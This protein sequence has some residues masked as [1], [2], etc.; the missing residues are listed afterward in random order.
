MG[1]WHVTCDFL[2]RR[3]ESGNLLYLPGGESPYMEYRENLST[4]IAVPSNL[5]LKFRVRQCDKSIQT[6][7]IRS[8][9]KRRILSEQDRLYYSPNATEEAN[10]NESDEM[11]KDFFDLKQVGWDQSMMLLR[12]DRKRY[13]IA[14]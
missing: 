6:E 3:S 12:S 7:P 1:H 5:T 9:V 2:T 10:V 11:E 8:P 13:Y 14:R 4:P